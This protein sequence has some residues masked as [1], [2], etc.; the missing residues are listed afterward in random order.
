MSQDLFYSLFYCDD[1]KFNLAGS[2]FVFLFMMTGRAIKFI[3]SATG[4]QPNKK[5]PYK[6]TNVNEM[7]NIW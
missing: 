6:F 5:V 1:Q 3:C 4:V 2:F 7:D